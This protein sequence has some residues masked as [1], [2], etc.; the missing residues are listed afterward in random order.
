MRYKIQ[1][2]DDNGYHANREVVTR[3]QAA[4]AVIA[5]PI[6]WPDNLL[7]ILGIMENRTR[8]TGETSTHYLGEHIAPIE[9]QRECPMCQSMADSYSK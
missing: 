9:R 1:T 6:I 4:A 3:N 5:A 2:F 7:G 8:R